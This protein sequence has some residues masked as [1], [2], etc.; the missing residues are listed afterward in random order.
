MIIFDELAL[1]V[2]NTNTCKAN[3]MSNN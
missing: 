1:D 2:V 3:E